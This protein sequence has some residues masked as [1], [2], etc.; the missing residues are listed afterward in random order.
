MKIH[1]LLFLDATIQL[2]S[3]NDLM[4]EESKNLR[5]MIDALHVRHKEHSEQIQAYISSHSTDQS[6][7][8]HLK[9]YIF[10]D[11]RQYGKISCLFL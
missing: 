3:I 7:L 5:E 6:E 4:K 11:S 1:I 2:S 9:G 8:K 10:H